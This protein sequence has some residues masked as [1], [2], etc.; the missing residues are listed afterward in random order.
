[1]DKIRPEDTESHKESLTE[2]AAAMIEKEL[3]ARAMKRT[4]P[5]RLSK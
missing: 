1:M 2:L 3:R 5:T 4:S